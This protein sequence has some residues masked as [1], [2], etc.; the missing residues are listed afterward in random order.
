[1]RQTTKGAGCGSEEKRRRRRGGEEEEEE[2][3]PFPTVAVKYLEKSQSA[4][5]ELP[6]HFPFNYN[7]YSF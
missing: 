5:F 1:M 3:L 4:R 2:E 7:G 6:F